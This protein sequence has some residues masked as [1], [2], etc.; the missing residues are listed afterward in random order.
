MNVYDHIITANQHFKPK[1]FHTSS[2]NE[3]VLT[4]KHNLEDKNVRDNQEKYNQDKKNLKQNQTFSYKSKLGELKMKIDTQ[5]VLLKSL[6]NDEDSCIFDFGHM[7]CDNSD[8]ELSDYY[9]TSYNSYC[10]SIE[11][12]NH[13]LDHNFNQNWSENDKIL[14]NNLI[15]IDCSIIENLFYR[16]KYHKLKDQV[17]NKSHS[18][19]NELLNQ[20]NTV[21]F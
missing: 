1:N 2:I 5:N 13:R 11:S 9:L 10:N 21:N 3:D 17:K 12:E 14:L 8:S 4:N 16:Q 7:E 20:F 19:F 15:N 18:S 6:N